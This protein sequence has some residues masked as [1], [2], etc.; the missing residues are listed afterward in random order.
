MK[1]VL[2]FCYCVLLWIGEHP[3]ED[4]KEREAL[5]RY[6]RL[7]STVAPSLQATFFRLRACGRA[8]LLFREN[9]KKD[10]RLWEH[11]ADP[12]AQYDFKV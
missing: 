3:R 4:T 11:I 10:E 1:P 8:G 2:R 5:R 7:V 6:V 9:P 12:S